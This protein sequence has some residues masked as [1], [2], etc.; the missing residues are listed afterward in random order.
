ME[1]NNTFVSPIGSVPNESTIATILTPDDSNVIRG[2]YGG[3]RHGG[4]F[5]AENPYYQQIEHATNNQDI[6]ALYEKAV[7][8][9]G[10]NSR[11]QEQRAYDEYLRDE[12]RAYARSVLEEQR[13]YDSPIQDIARQRAAGL[14]PDLQGSGSG[15]TS[16][17]SSAQMQIPDT[18]SLPAPNTPSQTKFSNKYDNA[19][20]V[21]NGINTA[22]NLFGTFVGGASQIVDSVA[23]MRALPSQINAAD[24]QSNL[25]NAE[26]NSIET[27]LPSNKE[28]QALR[29]QGVNLDNAGKVLSVLSNMRQFL[30]PES[31]ISPVL[32][33]MGVPDEQ[34]GAYS[35]AFQEY[36][37]NPSVIA[38]S[39]N[40]S[41]SA[42]RSDAQRRVFNEEYLSRFTQKHAELAEHQLDFEIMHQKLR[43]D[44]QSLINASGVSDDMAESV[45]VDAQNTAEQQKL[46]SMR[47]THDVNAFCTRLGQQVETINNYTKRRA[48]LLQ[49]AKQ[50][51]RELSPSERSEID[52]I[53]DTLPEIY[54]ASSNQLES[55]YSYARELT[56]RAWYL[57]DNPTY[58]PESGDIGNL[59]G[60]DAFLQW[61][62]ISWNDVV[63][64]AKSWTDIA[65]DVSGKIIG[66]VG[67]GVG[68]AV[69]ARG[70]STPHGT[71]TT[72]FTN[73]KSGFKPTSQT[74]VEPLF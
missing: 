49:R 10:D 35:S 70:G 21:F 66:A 60:E 23:K 52:F 62:S 7:N 68:A 58:D 47:I 15:G 2:K 55:L 11:L 6:D 5:S 41:V 61:S 34:H 69:A 18:Q 39:N 73:T 65:S 59:H 51:K 20:M 56:R 1:K 63:H 4:S 48:E 45:I 12:E 27:L 53:D 26:A 22:A 50:E 28:F 17:G 74:V 3:A 64:G 33:A 8:W 36:M 46:L 40:D 13:F 44:V 31:N 16:G 24:A 43:N 72:N 14:N 19:A 71:V 9:E 25:M 37:K 29:N 54:A 32:T 38:R 30:T 67:A 57:D 42:A